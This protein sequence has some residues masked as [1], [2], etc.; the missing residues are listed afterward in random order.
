MKLKHLQA[1]R[2][3][4]DLGSIQEASQRLCLTQPATSRIIRELESELGL[5]LL[6][7]TTRGA[8]LTEY[9]SHIVKR[10]CSI[11]REIERIGEY[12]DE[13]RGKLNGSLN[14]A[15]TAPTASAALFGTFADFV[16][17]RPNVALKILEMR[18]LQVEEALRNGT[19][20]IGLLTH[21]SD[22]ETFSYQSEL[23]YQ[24]DMMLAIGGSYRGPTSLSI[25]ELWEMPWL[26]LDLEQD[27]NSFLSVLA[28]SAGLP[29]PERVIRCSSYIMYRG[30]ARRT[31][32]VS[33]WTGPSEV[34][35][36]R[37]FDNG[38]MCRILVQDQV[39]A[40]NVRLAYLDRDL[41][42]RPVRDFALWLRSRVDRNEIYY[43]P[44]DFEF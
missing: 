31:K 32:A 12:V 34:L 28:A 43:D 20:D 27:E 21:F 19:A 2:A 6:I 37:H 24:L 3:V 35:V 40:V 36:R 9:A 33:I 23:L 14:V 7:R 22:R 1:L 26:T 30:L 38:T 8:T 29:L 25:T 42:T 18:T 13:M 10:A 44:H 5:P 4:A 11:D 17:E 15:V 16:H 41:M 39:P